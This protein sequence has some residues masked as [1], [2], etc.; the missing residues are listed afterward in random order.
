MEFVVVVVVVVAAA[1]VAVAAVNKGAVG[2]SRDSPRGRCRASHD[3]S[4][5]STIVVARVLC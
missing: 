1:A 2:F 3:S 5:L 4:I